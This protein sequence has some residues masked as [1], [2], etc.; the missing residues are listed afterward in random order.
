MSSYRIMVLLDHDHDLTTIKLKNYWV[1]GLCPQSSIL[2]TRKHNILETGSI[3][4]SGEG[5]GETTTL[6]GP[7]ERTNLNPSRDKE[8]ASL[9]PF[10]I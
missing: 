2:E 1:F 5:G 8:R 7:L 10:R 6:L 3:S 4:S 9:N